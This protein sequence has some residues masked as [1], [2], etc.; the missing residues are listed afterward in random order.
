MQYANIFTF[1]SRFL[2]TFF[3]LFLYI[4]FQQSLEASSNNAKYANDSLYYLKFRDAYYAGK[5]DSAIYYSQ[6]LYNESRNS[7]NS[8]LEIRAIRSIAF[9]Y[10]NLNDFDNSLKYYNQAIQVSSQ[11]ENDLLLPIVYNDMGILYDNFGKYDS[12]LSYYYKSL[13]Y[14]EKLNQYDQ[15][16]YALNNIGTIYSNLS[17]TEAALQIFLQSLETKKKYGITNQIVFDYTNI[18][19]TYNALENPIEAL[20]YLNEALILCDSINCNS[21]E[22]ATI[23]NTIGESHNLL[24]NFEL[25]RSYLL[26]ANQI[27]MESRDFYHQAISL[28][29]LSDLEM[30][31]GQED[32]ALIYLDEALKLTLDHNLVETRKN[33][34]YSIYEIYENQGDFENAFKYQKLFTDLKDSLFN[35][36]VASNMRDIVVNYETR[37]ARETISAQDSEIRQRKQI[38]FLFGLVILLTISI[39]IRFFLDLNQKKKM[40]KRLDREV[41]KKTHELRVALNQ[42][43]QSKN[44]LDNLIYNISHEIRGPL[45]TLMGLIKVGKMEYGSEDTIHTYLN[46][47]DA[48]AN[49]L[50]SILKRMIIINSINHYD[51]IVNNVEVKDVVEE[52]INQNDDLKQGALTVHTDYDGVRSINTDSSLLATVI[53][54]IIDNSIRYRDKKE[55]NP[56]LDIK[57]RPGAESGIDIILSDNGIGFD[58]KYKNNIMDLFFVANEE[59]GEGIGLHHAKLAIQKLEGKIEIASS[60]K[61]TTFIVHLPEIK[62]PE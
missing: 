2:V 34:Y 15:I 54:N 32:K 42:L 61:P 3:V 50:N 24:G 27:S 10:R 5:Y 35:E 22:R 14:A 39:I 23:F 26:Q 30:N 58:P 6:V 25:S 57:I 47:L 49:N 21:S 31:L 41:A 37:E 33:T 1:M 44:D 9:T 51:T 40:N 43:Q 16:S 8:N 38:N 12:A 28:L 60:R 62:K 59:A 7:G 46:K 48:T 53:E 52:V 13:D 36:E 19:I 4:G 56:A 29:E 55:E 11:R 18:G 20:E 17:N 45:A